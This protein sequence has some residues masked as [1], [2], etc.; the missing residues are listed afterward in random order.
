MDKFLACAYNS[1][2]FAQTQEILRGRTTVKPWHLETL[3]DTWHRT[4]DTW[5]STHGGKW[6]F[7]EKFRSLALMVWAWRCS[8]DL[9]E[10]DERLT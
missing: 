2:D 7:S 1:Q 3:P 6:T 5:N 10:K 8:E 9:E 4:P